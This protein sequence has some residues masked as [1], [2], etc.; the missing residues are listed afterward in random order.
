MP[1]ALRDDT[2]QPVALAPVWLCG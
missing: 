1:T 2:A